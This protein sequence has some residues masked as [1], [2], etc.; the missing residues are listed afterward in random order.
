MHCEV[1]TGDFF[2]PGTY[3]SQGIRFVLV[4]AD[5]VVVE[6]SPK[7][8]THRGFEILRSK[9]LSAIIIFFLFAIAVN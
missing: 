8:N 4:E 6:C 9:N 7:C 5:L 2:T 3:T 1:K